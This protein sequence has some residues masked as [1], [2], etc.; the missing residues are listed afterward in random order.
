MTVPSGGGYPVLAAG[1]VPNVYEPVNPSFDK[2][3]L[4]QSGSGVL[5]G[6][7]F[8]ERFTSTSDSSLFQ[9]NIS[10]DVMTVAVKVPNFY[11]DDSGSKEIH[12]PQG[13]VIYLMKIGNVHK[14]A[15]GTSRAERGVGMIHN[16]VFG[17]V[18]DDKVVQAAQNNANH[19]EAMLR[20]GQVSESLFPT[21][22]L[23]QLFSVKTRLPTWQQQFKMLHTFLC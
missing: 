1:D 9:P 2:G 18:P 20:Y 16:M 17:R 5:S 4:Q 15:P 12:L 14:W 6:P 10:P 3:L 7:V 13:T 19:I 11:F 22:C 8:G 21:V 23:G